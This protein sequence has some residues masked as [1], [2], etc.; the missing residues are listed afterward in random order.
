MWRSAPGQS[1]VLAALD[2][3][4]E[5]LPPVHEGTEVTVGGQ[6][7]RARRRLGSRVGTPD[8]R[9]RRRSGSRRGRHGLR[10]ARQNRRYCRHF[11]RRLRPA[12][13]LM[14]TNA[15][16]RLHAFCHAV[17]GAWHFMGVML[18]A[19]GS[20]QWYKDTLRAGRSSFDS[21]ARRSGGHPRRQRRACSSCRT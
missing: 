10:R 9:R 13:P 21:L 2:I 6:W 19:A 20:L 7:R 17:P 14:L 12:E 3:P 8:R 1:E 16:G 11:R 15:E 4:A 18:S 5:W